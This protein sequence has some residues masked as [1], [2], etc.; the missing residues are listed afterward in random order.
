MLFPWLFVISSAAFPF[1][2]LSTSLASFA[3]FLSS[4]F[5]SFFASFASFALFLF[6]CAMRFAS[7]IAFCFPSLAS[8]FL[9]IEP[10]RELARE[11]LCLGGALGSCLGTCD[12]GESG[13]PV[14]KQ[15]VQKRPHGLRELR[16]RALLLFLGPISVT[17]G[18]RGCLH[19]NGLCVMVISTHYMAR[20]LLHYTIRPCSHFFSHRPKR[21]AASNGRLCGGSNYFIRAQRWPRSPDSQLE[22]EK[23]SNRSEVFC[24]CC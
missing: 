11:A 3:L 5:A 22:S 1:S 14:P 8:F 10:E 21:G 4:F 24:C 16:R 23:S 13:A 17:A 2:A 7:P 9:Y 19:G 6:S 15:R 20:P 12:C 18:A